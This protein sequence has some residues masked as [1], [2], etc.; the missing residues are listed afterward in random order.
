MGD[1]DGGE[2]GSLDVDGERAVG[3]QKE[4]MSSIMAMNGYRASTEKLD[5]Q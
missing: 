3:R 4:F 2:D 5:R 1:W